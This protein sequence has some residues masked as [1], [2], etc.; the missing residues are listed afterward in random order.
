M[1]LVDAWTIFLVLAAAAFLGTHY[2]DLTFERSGEWTIM[3][4]P[5]TFSLIPPGLMPVSEVEAHIESIR[6]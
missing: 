2:V 4:A 5:P 3:H 1:R 6:P